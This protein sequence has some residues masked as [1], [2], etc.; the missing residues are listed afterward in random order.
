M[1]QGK[2]C[3]YLSVFILFLY[4]LLANGC[5]GGSDGNN[6]FVVVSISPDEGFGS[7]GISSEISVK[8]SQPVATDSVTPSTF[9][10][11]DTKSGEKVK[12]QYEFS[13]NQTRVNFKPGLL[14]FDRPYEVNVYH[15]ITNQAGVHLESD[16][17]IWKFFTQARPPLFDQ[18]PKPNATSVNPNA[19]IVVE[20]ENSILETT[21]N[22]SSFILQDGL[23]QVP[24]TVTLEG[25]TGKL[26]PLQ[27]LQLNKS[28]SVTLNSSILQTDNTVAFPIGFS[29]SFQTRAAVTSTF[30]VGT[31]K[32]DIVFSGVADN[33]GGIYLT[34]FTEGSFEGFVNNGE[35]DRFIAKYS[36]NGTRQW[37]T[38]EGTE[39]FDKNIQILLGTDGNLYVSGDSENGSFFLP[40][41]SPEDVQSDILLASYSPSG[42]Q[43]W[44]VNFGSSDGH[45]FAAGHVLDENNNIYLVGQ[46]MGALAGQVNQGEHDIIVAKYD[47]SGNKL[48]EKQY[49]SADNETTSAPQVFGA[50]VFIPVSANEAISRDLPPDLIAP[51]PGMFS[52]TQKFSYYVLNANGEK[53][54]DIPIAMEK[55][56]FGIRSYIGP[57][58]NIHLAGTGFPREAT[59][60]V[61]GPTIFIE[62]YTANGQLQW[63]QQW[64]ENLNGDAGSIIV[65]ESGNIYVA[66]FHFDNSSIVFPPSPSPIQSG[67]NHIMI[68]KLDV[69]GNQSWMKKIP[70]EEHAFVEDMS[71]SANNELIAVG[72]THGG[73]DGNSAIGRGDGFVLRLD[74][75][76]GSLL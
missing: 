13:E 63:S 18:F 45:D 26:T 20:F 47:N 42:A 44:Q 53:I 43:Q 4:A 1:S 49:G 67:N 65:D 59:E 50:E 14:A 75:N 58:G 60:P 16:T 3:S 22:N 28:Y 37:V 15:S 29:W 21:L 68:L 40:N 70:I 61:F 38:Q 76:T 8:F 5:G 17:K 52:P 10:I 25:D 55:I 12:G 41:Q 66:A 57:Q 36:I 74:R 54:N 7:V 46:S 9:Y 2:R 71:L 31:A 24:A 48:W 73:I 33:Q 51:P 6:G 62:K 35:F 32:E 39:R 30:Q 23:V 11:V 64:P 19:S 34:G 56:E 27:P 69:N 72:A